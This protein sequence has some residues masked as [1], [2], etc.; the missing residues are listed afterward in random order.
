MFNQKLDA[1]KM[2][3]PVL[4]VSTGAFSLSSLPS[5]IQMFKNVATTV[6]CL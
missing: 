5:R 2:F 3:L 1:V 4:S 6:H